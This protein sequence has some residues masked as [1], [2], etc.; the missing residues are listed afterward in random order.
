M[1]SFATQGHWCAHPT[2]SACDTFSAAVSTAS[3]S[4][5]NHQFD[6]SGPRGE[7]AG[8]NAFTAENVLRI[9]AEMEG[10]VHEELD[11]AQMLWVDRLGM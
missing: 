9:A 10:A 11:D 4:R 1:A 2:P 5:L 6:G 3:A 7:R 8:S